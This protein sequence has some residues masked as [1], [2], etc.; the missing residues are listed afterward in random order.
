MSSRREERLADGMLHTPA[1]KLRST[2]A[3]VIIT[4]WVF[5]I[6]H[7]FLAFHFL[8]SSYLL[9][10]PEVG[11]LHTSSAEHVPC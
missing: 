7:L 3:E 5:F 8:L 1:G 9:T 4:V 11:F 6:L 2:L 10:F